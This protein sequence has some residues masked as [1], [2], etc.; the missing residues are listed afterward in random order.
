MQKSG[1][2]GFMYKM[3]LIHVDCALPFQL[4]LHAVRKVLVTFFQL[5]KKSE[6]CKP[7]GKDLL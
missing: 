3:L 4:V 2:F 1:Y 5:K 6:L 7:I